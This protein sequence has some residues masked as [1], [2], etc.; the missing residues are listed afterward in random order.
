M[1]RD[2]WRRCDNDRPTYVEY[3]LPA[4]IEERCVGLTKALGLRFGTIDL[5]LTPQHE[6]VFL[7]INPN[8]GWAFLQELVGMPIGMAIADLLASASVRE[9]EVS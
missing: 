3:Q 6:Y 7:E 5:I 4:E 9:L 2:D 1:T 8:G